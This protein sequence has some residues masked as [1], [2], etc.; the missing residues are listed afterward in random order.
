V[1]ARKMTAEQA[2][3]VFRD[4]ITALAGQGKTRITAE[5][6][7]DLLEQTGRSRPWLYLIFAELE[8]SGELR[9]DDSGWP[10]EW[11]ITRAA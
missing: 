11:V 3:E 5:D 1:P 9:K 8:K 7:I 6:V 2:R 4:R 10:T